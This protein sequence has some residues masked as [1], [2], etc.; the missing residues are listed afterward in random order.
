M[1]GEDEEMHIK[2]DIDDDVGGLDINI[3]GREELEQAK[4]T[5]NSQTTIWTL[6]WM[7]L[8]PFPSGR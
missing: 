7:K 5:M 6:I 3:E 4:R 2:E 8:Q 1:G